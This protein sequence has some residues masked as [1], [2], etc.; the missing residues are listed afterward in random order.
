MWGIVGEASSEKETEARQY[1]SDVSTMRL[2]SAV[3][4]ESMR[5][6]EEA[7]DAPAPSPTPSPT[8][9]PILTS[10]PVV[11]SL[12]DGGGDISLSDP[13]ESGAWQG[14]AKVS[15]AAM[16]DPICAYFDSSPYGC[17]YW[18]C[19]AERESSLIPANDRNPPYVGLF[20]IDK[21]LHHDLILSLGYT[22]DEMFIAGPNSHVAWVL[23]HQG[24][25]TFP[26]PEARW[27]C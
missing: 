1:M 3:E 14:I 19:I 18:F 7:I 15:S 4:Q 10:S 11:Q 12:P 27:L 22:I 2:L 5:L 6:W 9:T 24:V 26:W 13:S 20:Q 17:E 16:R 25:Y 8:P 23:S 21:N